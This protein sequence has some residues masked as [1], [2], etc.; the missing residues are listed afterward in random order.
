MFYLVSYDIVDDR[1]RT[2]VSKVLLGYGNRVQKSV[3]ECVIT[4]KQFMELRERVERLLDFEWDSVRYYK[5]C[6]KCLET[7]EVAGWGA[8]TEDPRSATLIV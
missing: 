7:V 6:K 4:E 1:K 3:F 2:A 8:V 5:L